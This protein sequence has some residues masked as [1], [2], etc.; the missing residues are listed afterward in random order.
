MK[1][2]GLVVAV[3]VLVGFVGTAIAWGPGA[4]RC[5][6]G[7][8][9]GGGHGFG[10]WANLDLSKD[11]VDKLAALKD[12]QYQDT[13]ALRKDLFQKRIEARKL[14]T[15]PSATDKVILDKQTELNAIQQQLR[16]KMV[17]FKLE[18]R[19]ILT[20]EQLK[21]L[22]EFGPGAGRGRGPGAGPGGGRGFGP[23]AGPGAPGA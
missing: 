12:K 19:K 13:S 11:Q 3:L 8:G 16:N 20:P 5:G 14:F 10:A 7:P 2:L 22:G 6:H 4:G 1:K 15:D 9:A 18:E 17:Q 21:K 23:G